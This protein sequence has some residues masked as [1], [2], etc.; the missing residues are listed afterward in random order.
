MFESPTRL[1]RRRAGALVTASAAA[2]AAASL[3]ATSG[4]SA[5]AGTTTMRFHAAPFTQTRLPAPPDPND[6]IQV[7]DRLLWVTELSQG[8]AHVGSASHVCTA[9]DQRWLDCVATIALP[10]GQ[11]QLQTALDI[12]SSDLPPIA[13]TGG[14]GCYRQARGQ[15]VIAP[16]D[17]GSAEWTLQLAGSC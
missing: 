14:S 3:I 5:D 10:R 16:N 8:T 9:A 2:V 4:A 12:T 11:V 17:D 15:L 13:V 7:G 6:P 1:M